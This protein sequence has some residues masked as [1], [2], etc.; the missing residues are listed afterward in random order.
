MKDFP[1]ALAAHLQQDATTLCRC[2]R[3][4]RR[5]GAVLGFTDH[6]RT[7]VLDGT[8]FSA[9]TGFSASDVESGLGLQVS[10]SAVAGALSGEALSAA[11]LAEGLYDGARIE[12]FLVNWQDPAM[13]ALTDVFELGEVKRAD[14]AFEAELRSVTHRLDQ[15][16]G[17]TYGHRCDAVL[18]DA[19]CGVD[20]GKPGLKVAASVA[21]IIDETR[22]V[23]AG[24]GSPEKGFFRH[25]RLVFSGGPAAGRSLDIAE[26]GPSGTDLT[27]VLWQ[28]LPAGV[29]AGDSVVLVAGCDKRFSTC[30]NRFANAA[31][32][33]G[34]PHMPGTD[35]AY[36]TVHADGVH[37]GRPLFR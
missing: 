25:G 1:H 22:L 37:D 24:A 18:G 30:R 34:F 21:S 19:R 26:H 7:I 32:F 15:K 6:D 29:A 28:P 9:T 3:L 10:N 4:T 27:V 12:V 14:Q 35:F 11:D 20:L 36:G 5:D 13:H 31:N 8:E 16:Q 33:R 23:V 17:R 2:W